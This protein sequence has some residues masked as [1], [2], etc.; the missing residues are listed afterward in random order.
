MAK[1]LG[2]LRHEQS[3][4]Q[5]EL[6]RA[7]LRDYFPPGNVRSERTCRSGWNQV[8]LISNELSSGVTAKAGL[9]KP[10]QGIP[11]PQQGL[12]HVSCCARMGFVRAG[13]AGVQQSSRLLVPMLSC[14]HTLPESPRLHHWAA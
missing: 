12:P 13:G 9:Q 7:A 5:G 11:P 6:Q 8:S 1:T 4:L 14:A 3:L 10:I 2:K